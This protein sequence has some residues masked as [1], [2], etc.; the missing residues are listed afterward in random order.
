MTLLLLIPK[1][2]TITKIHHLI[3]LRFE[4]SEHKKTQRDNMFNEI[5]LQMLTILLG[6]VVS[7]L[8]FHTGGPGPIPRLGKSLNL[9]INFF[10]SFSSCRN[11]Q[12][13][14]F[15]LAIFRI[16]QILSSERASERKGMPIV[17]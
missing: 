3:R 15:R 8:A 2:V 14:L 17:E 12:T 7:D 4:Q 10:F 9:Q 1:K 16:T 5:F 11:H 13:F 6:I